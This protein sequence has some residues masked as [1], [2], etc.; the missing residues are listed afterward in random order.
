MGAKFLL[1]KLEWEA[2]KWLVSGTGAVWRER[3][4]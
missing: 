2:D 1:F 4:W 3:V